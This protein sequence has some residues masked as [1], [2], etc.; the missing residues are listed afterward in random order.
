MITK[1]DED[2][3]ID[4]DKI[5]YI[6]ETT[7]GIIVICNGRSVEFNSAMG[8]RLIDAFIQ[9]HRSHM[10]NYTNKQAVG[11]KGFLNFDKEGE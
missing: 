5:S 3:Y 1:L 4:I 10:Y 7:K 6:G 2:T 9:N 8:E 11:Y